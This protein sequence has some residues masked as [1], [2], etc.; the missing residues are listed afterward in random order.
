MRVAL[1]L[2]I[3]A[4]A[5]AHMPRAEAIELKRGIGVHEWLN[6]APLDDTGLHYRKPLYQTVDQWRTRYRE[7]GDWPEGDEFA[8]IRRMGFDFIRLTV[9]PGPLLDKDGADRAEGL[10]VLEESIR[11]VTAQDLKVV[12]D[13]HLV[14]QVEAFGQAAMEVAV[15]SPKLDAYRELLG[16]TA[17]MLTS[18]GVDK[19]AFEPMNE[20]QFYPCD[21][22][23]GQEWNAVMGSFV[24]SIRA[25]SSDLTI[26]A[27]GACGGGPYGLMQL[28]PSAF[29]DPA[30][31]YSFHA[32]EPHSFSHQGV[33]DKA[34]LTGLPWPAS[35]R[36]RAEV[37]AMSDELM[38]AQ[39]LGPLERAM[40][41]GMLGGVLHEYYAEAPGPAQ[42]R[43]S[44]ADVAAWAE[45]HD[46]ASDRIFVGEFGVVRL[47]PD[48]GGATDQDR[49]RYLETVRTTA[50][51]YG[52]AWSLW[53]YSNPHGMSLIEPQGPAV[54]EPLIL[55]AL[56]L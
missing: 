33:G 55:R 50:E 23:A 46:I 15:E 48:R 38:A 39:G 20:P 36:S 51:G 10:A 11:L 29:E 22:W 28:D 30:I 21:G 56:G 5:S 54:P 47:Q 16:D 49:Y 12:F 37:E 27:T 7:L 8:R 32:Y 13:F 14:P 26:I 40:T 53:E 25:V 43:Q 41:L 2:S 9:D 4:L 31:L 35:G 34:Y 19:V 3:L 45:R 44:F 52:M 24:A 6:W 18:I 17:R 42:L 1:C